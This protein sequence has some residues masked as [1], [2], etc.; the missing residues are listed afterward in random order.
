MMKKLLSGHRFV[1]KSA[2]L[3]YTSIKRSCRQLDLLDKVTAA[4]VPGHFGDA[5]QLTAAD[6]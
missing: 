5:W 2:E 1:K 6:N 3:S 4:K